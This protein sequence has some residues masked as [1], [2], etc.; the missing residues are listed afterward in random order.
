MDTGKFLHTNMNAYLKKN[1][2]DQCISC[3]NCMKKS[4]KMLQYKYN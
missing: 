3:Q 2:A 1:M 4:D